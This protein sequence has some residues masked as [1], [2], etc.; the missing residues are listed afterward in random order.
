MGLLLS[1]QSSK[2]LTITWNAYEDE[3]WNGNH[4]GFKIEITEMESGEVMNI[5]IHSSSASSKTVHSLHPYYTYECRIAAFNVQ[6]T[7]PYAEAI[8]QL[9]QDGKGRLCVRYRGDGSGRGGGG[10]GGGTGGNTLC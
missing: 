9:P 3:E 2:S 8:L 10:G 1:A 4:G 7:G 5:T 6:G